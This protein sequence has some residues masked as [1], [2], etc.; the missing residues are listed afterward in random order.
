MKW[1]RKLFPPRETFTVQMHVTSHEGVVSSFAPIEGIRSLE[2]A[3]RVAHRLREDNKWAS[4]DRWPS[5]QIHNN[6]GEWFPE[7]RDCVV[8]EKDGSLR[9][10][11]GR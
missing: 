10:W 3:R 1:L 4:A 6:A 11:R 8:R 2:E 7:V 9:H 5:V